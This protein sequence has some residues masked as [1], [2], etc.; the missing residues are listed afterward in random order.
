[1]Q[2][3]RHGKRFAG[4][5]AQTGNRTTDE[6]LTVL[7]RRRV[8]D[9]GTQAMRTEARTIAGAAEVLAGRTG[10]SEVSYKGLILSRA[11]AVASPFGRK[12]YDGS[13]DISLY[14]AKKYIR[15]YKRKLEEVYEGEER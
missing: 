1:M 13:W 2:W 4:P 9:A 3:R 6:R 10:Y 8:K 12:Q 5:S 15:W 7:A 11:A 14:S